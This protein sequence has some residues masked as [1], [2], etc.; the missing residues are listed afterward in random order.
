MSKGYKGIPGK[1]TKP[2]AKVLR[3][4]FDPPAP[5]IQRCCDETVQREA[6]P[7]ETMQRSAALGHSVTHF[8]AGTPIQ[9]KLTLGPVGDAYEQEADQVARQVSDQVANGGEVAEASG[10]ERVQRQGPE[11]EEPE[12]LQMKPAANV[13]RQGPEDEEL[14][15]KGEPGLAGG[16]PITSDVESSIESA[17]GGGRPLEEGVRAP[18]ESAFGADFGDVKVHADS[19][20]DSLNES[21]QARAFTTGQDIFFRQGEYSPESSGGS[22]LL[23]HELTHVVQQNGDAVRKKPERD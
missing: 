9:T 6:D 2:G 8:A 19:G 21:L 18:M 3:G 14:Q 22:E 12:E 1:S 5:A 13:Q 15:M 17:R 11:D 23:A 20:A 16:G 7:D 4:R 10:E